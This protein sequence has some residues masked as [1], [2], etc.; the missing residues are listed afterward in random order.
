MSENPDDYYMQGT[1]MDGTVGEDIQFLAY[2]EM[3]PDMKYY[4]VAKRDPSDDALP[5]QGQMM[6]SVKSGAVGKIMLNGFIIP[7]GT[8]DEYIRDIKRGAMLAIFSAIG[9]AFGFEVRP[10]QGKVNENE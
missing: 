8:E 4:K 6:E 2:V 7:K 10:L 5:F 9:E 3:R 1:F